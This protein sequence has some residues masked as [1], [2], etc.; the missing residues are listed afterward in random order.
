MVGEGL[1][2]KMGTTKKPECC[3]QTFRTNSERHLD[4][5]QALLKHG[6]H[7]AFGVPLYA[8][9]KLQAVL[10][11]FSTATQPPDQHLL[12]IAESIGEQLG[13]VLERQRGEE[14][15][16]QAVAISDALD[17]KTIRSEA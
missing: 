11:F 13:R 15:Q 6:L 14:Q 3:C 10:E 2:G 17:L 9:G 7:A 8:E 12:Y 1:P 4:R 5:K 16:R